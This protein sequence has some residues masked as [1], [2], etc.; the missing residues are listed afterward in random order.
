MA[1]EDEHGPSAGTIREPTL[2]RSGCGFR[3][4]PE[5]LSAGID[6]SAAP[7]LLEPAL[8]WREGTATDGEATGSHGDASVPSRTQ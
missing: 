4:A 8:E 3:Y 5:D 6:F 2:H 1:D 7:Q